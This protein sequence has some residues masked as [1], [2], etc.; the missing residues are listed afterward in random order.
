MVQNLSQTAAAIQKMLHSENVDNEMEDTEGLDEENQGG[1]TQETPK[2]GQEGPNA[3]EMVENSLSKGIENVTL[4]DKSGDQ[5]M[6]EG[7]QKKGK[8]KVKKAKKTQHEL[9]VITKPPVPQEILGLT[10]DLD[11]AKIL[12]LTTQTTASKSKS[13]LMFS[14]D[15]IPGYNH[16]F[17]NNLGPLQVWELAEVQALLSDYTMFVAMITRVSQTG[18]VA[19]DPHIKLLVEELKKE[20]DIK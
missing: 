17:N 5:V 7:G 14:S 10:K 11:L 19:T 12:G 18:N 6:E 16:F 2:A 15:D 1:N 8:G 4:N 20:L 9:V 3:A 13:V